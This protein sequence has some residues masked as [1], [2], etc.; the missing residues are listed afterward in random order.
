[1][2]GI[3]TA[4]RVVI[5][6][7]EDKI[8]K[9]EKFKLLVEGLVHPVLYDS[10]SFNLLHVCIHIIWRLFEVGNLDQRVAQVNFSHRLVLT[11]N[12]VA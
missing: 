12:I 5:S 2:Q 9:A 3:K 6:K 4:D 10:C 1:L 8:T 7:E 11:R